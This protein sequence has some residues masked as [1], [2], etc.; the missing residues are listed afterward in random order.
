[1]SEQAR[2][3]FRLAILT[4]SDAGSK[5][6]RA[7]TSGDA[8]SEI[9]ACAGLREVE[10]A[11]VPDEKDLVSGRLAQWCDGGGVDVVLTTGGTGL[12]P[13][14][15]TPEATRAV[16][17]L[18]VPGIGEAMRMGT[19]AKTPFA[20]LSRSVAGAR[21]GCLIVNLPGSP[22]GV[23]E[24]LGVAMPAIPHALEMLKGWRTHAGG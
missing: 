10:R 8:I 11:I 4:I 16:I 19:L 9:A 23:R 7:D 1:M 21:S 2:E 22:T 17:E 14:D 3:P 12:G 5:G 20:I 13:R 18:E 6:E 15:V 24:C